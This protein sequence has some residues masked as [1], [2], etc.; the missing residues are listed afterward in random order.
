MCTHYRS[1]HGPD[2]IREVFRAALTGPARNTG[3]EVYPDREAP[4]VLLRGG[5]RVVEFM[6]WGFPSPPA[7]NGPPVVNVRN[8]SSP[9]WRPWLKPGQRCLVPFSAFS[10]WEDTKPR[11]TERWF[12]LWDEEPMAAFAGIWRPWTGMRG[13][14]KDPIDGEHL[15]FSFL[16]SEPNDVVRPIH[17][18]AMPVVLTTP[19]EWETWLHAPVEIALE[20]QRPLPEDR[21]LRL[22]G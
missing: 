12:A 8:V 18:K 22:V 6:R 4:V 13:T 7:I 21:G 17:P 1:Q 16:T 14:K 19:G 5:E 10:E 11:K 15:L 20:L 3:S 9:F 2:M